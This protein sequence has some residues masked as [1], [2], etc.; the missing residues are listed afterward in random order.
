[1]RGV[2]FS[3]H[4]RRTRT[5]LLAALGALLAVRLAVAVFTPVF[6]PS[7]ARYAAISANMARS[8]DFLVPR[9]T[10]EGVYRS[11]DGKPP[12]LFQAGGVFCRVFGVNEFAVRLF[13]ILSAL[14]LLAILHHAVRRLGG[15]TAGGLAVAV[16]ASCVAFYAAGGFC[17]MDMPLTCCSSGA[18]LLHACFAQDRRK[19]YS[20]GVFALLGAGMLVKGPIAVI[21]FGLPV[22]LDAALNRRWDVLR[23][24]AWVQGPLVFLA[25][26]APWFVAMQ[27]QNPGFLEYFFVN[28]NLLRFL[29]HD[30]GDKYGAGRETFRGMALVWSL[31]VTMPWSLVPLWK[32][33]R[34][35]LERYREGMGRSSSLPAILRGAP[36]LLRGRSVFLLGILSITAFWCLTSRV[37]LA[38]L[39]PVIPLFAAEF[40]LR[41]DLETVRRL[42]PAAS[43]VC[44][45]ALVG[46]VA[47][48]MAFT[49]KMPGASARPS[50]RGHRFS[51][52]FYHGSAAT[53]LAYGDKMTLKE[54]PACP[55]N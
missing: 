3:A 16:C 2:S 31:V 35:L 44:M 36:A 37:P 38:Y 10:Y 47:C 52:E 34:R 51:H 13:P 23:A 29:V 24:H 53:A 43:A 12:L 39:L 27:R 50:K 46:T 22:G 45:V 1:M 42:L 33:G 15:R 9:F 40:A 48:T 11:F 20:L 55:K 41:A 28:E 25:I 6:D 54:A 21:L 8:G 18:V 17:M 7:E 30:Y 5:I 49:N 14:L 26:A 19:V 32:G 4:M